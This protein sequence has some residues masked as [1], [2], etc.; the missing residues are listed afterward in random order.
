MKDLA[1]IIEEK[2]GKQNL[3]S[4]EDAKMDISSK[5]SGF[6]WIFTKLPLES[7]LVSDTPSNPVHIDFSEMAKIH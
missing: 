5:D 4:L 1:V 6:Y 3:L 2:L 7:F